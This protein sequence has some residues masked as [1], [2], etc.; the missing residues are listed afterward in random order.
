[1]EQQLATNTTLAR[2]LVD[3]RGSATTPAD[4]RRQAFLPGPS[5]PRLLH[6]R[7]PQRQD[8]RPVPRTSR[9][10]ASVV[11]LRAEGRVERSTLRRWAGSESGWTAGSMRWVDDAWGDFDGDVV[12]LEHRPSALTSDRWCGVRARVVVAFSGGRSAPSERRSPSRC[13]RSPRRARGSGRLQARRQV[14][15]VRADVTVA[16]EVAEVPTCTR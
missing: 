8:L 6:R 14:D 2:H 5:P 4:S 7:R 16:A 12:A 15:R 1:V 11:V 3:H 9:L 13:G 10:R